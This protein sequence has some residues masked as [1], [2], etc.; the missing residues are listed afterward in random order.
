MI[1][2]SEKSLTGKKADAGYQKKNGAIIIFAPDAD[3][4]LVKVEDADGKEKNLALVKLEEVTN[5]AESTKEQIA[6]AK[7]AY[8]SATKDFLEKVDQKKKIVDK[9]PRKGVVPLELLDSV[10]TPGIVKVKGAAKL[11]ASY[12]ADKKAFP[13]STV[14]DLFEAGI[15]PEVLET[16]GIIW[17]DYS[18]FGQEV[19][20]V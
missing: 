8:D 16:T 7:K 9:L 10:R 3:G 1:L 5:D 17:H 15:D 19:S 13:N 11:F 12:E 2:V 14:K 4:S 20:V 18:Q 6:E